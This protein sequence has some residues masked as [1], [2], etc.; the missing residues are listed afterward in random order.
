[1]S[2]A[3]SQRGEVVDLEILVADLDSQVTDLEHIVD[4]LREELDTLK[5][6]RE[7][8]RS[9]LE[10]LRDQLDGM[11]RCQ[12]ETMKAHSIALHEADILF[13]RLEKAL[14]QLPGG[15]A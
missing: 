11:E 13:E 12:D 4:D 2:K 8:D 7:E 6:E 1:M 10:R 15:A 14:A 3:A 5:R 9:E